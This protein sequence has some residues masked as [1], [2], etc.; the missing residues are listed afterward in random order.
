[1]S[2]PSFLVIDDD[3][4]YRLRLAKALRSRGFETYETAAPTEALELA[5]K[6]Q[7][8]RVILDLRLPEKSGLA[9]LRELR[10]VSIKSRVVMLTGY[11]SIAT[12]LEA[13]KEGAVHYLTKPS[14]LD[15][16]LE[17]FLEEPKAESSPKAVPSLS[18]VE[19]EHIERVMADCDGNV[20]KA[21]KLLGLHRR[22]LQ[23]KLKS[24]P[25]KR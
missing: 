12:A 4:P 6:H 24:M 18:R 8:D 3:E 23:R 11:G 5:V 15:Q 19:W 1:M 10:A 14:D 20:S 22:S 17:A 16:I 13:V 21:A 7:P 9:L 2:E 25:P